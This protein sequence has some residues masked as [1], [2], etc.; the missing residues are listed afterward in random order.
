MYFWNPRSREALPPNTEWAKI[1][2]VMV[3][4][5]DIGPV[6]LFYSGLDYLDDPWNN[7]PGVSL[8]KKFQKEFTVSASATRN[9]NKQRWM[10]LIGAAWEP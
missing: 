6:G 7:L 9:M 3:Y 8:K 2:Y 5:L 4:Q 1:G 10:F